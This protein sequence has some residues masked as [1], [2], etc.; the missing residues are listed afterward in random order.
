MISY[1]TW[2]DSSD[3]VSSEY[4]NDV[5]SQSSK[6]VFDPRSTEYFYHHS[7]SKYSKLLDHHKKLISEAISSLDGLNVLSLGAGTCWLEASLLAGLDFNRLT[8]VDFSKYRLFNVA[9]ITFEYHG[10]NTSD[11][12]LIHGNITDLRLKASSQHLI[13]LCQAFH[14][15]PDPM[16]L[17]SELARVAADDALI[18]ISGEHLYSFADYFKRI[19]SHFRSFTIS[20][21]YRRLHSLYP[22]YPT[23]FPHCPLKGDHHYS[24]TSYSSM[25]STYGFAFRRF[26]CNSTGTQ[27]FILRKAL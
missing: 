15:V 20:P 25:F 21:S 22:D 26:K 2:L 11:I 18:I 4:W 19:L 14:H 6:T 27:S 5:L 8:V 17:L 1:D 10:H 7:N 24:L 13:L 16:K 9:P 23:L 12:Q 3:D